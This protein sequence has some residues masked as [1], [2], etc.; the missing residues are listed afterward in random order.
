MQSLQTTTRTITI[1]ATSTATNCT[2]WTPRRG[3][4]AGAAT[5]PRTRAAAAPTTAATAAAAA[6]D[7]PA[8]CLLPAAPAGECPF[9]S[10]CWYLHLNPDGTPAVMG[11]PTLRLDSDGV[12][13][14]ARPYK[15]S[16][17][18]FGGGAR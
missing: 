18:L 15:L 14:S 7:M 12:A 4:R 6:V 17:F 11:R 13:A 5:S 9:G 16:E 1:T 2:R 10:S 3:L 8:A